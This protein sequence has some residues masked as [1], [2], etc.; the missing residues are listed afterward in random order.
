MMRLRKEWFPV[1]DVRVLDML[2]RDD[3]AVIVMVPASELSKSFAIYAK[4]RESYLNRQTKRSNFDLFVFLVHCCH[5]L[6]GVMLLHLSAGRAFFPE[7][8]AASSYRRRR[9]SSSFC[10]CRRTVSA[11][12]LRRPSSCRCLWRCVRGGA[13]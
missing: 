7:S 3:P 12:D 6:A 8:S 11:G 1:S 13:R 5:K 4:E 10:A 2:T 9:P